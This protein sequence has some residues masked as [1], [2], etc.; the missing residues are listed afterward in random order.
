M[1]RRIFKKKTLSEW[2]YSF[3]IFLF[4][5]LLLFFFPSFLPNK[6]M[7]PA[8]PPKNCVGDLNH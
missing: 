8:F 7:L 5:F 4:S 6:Y 2:L 3:F 1:I